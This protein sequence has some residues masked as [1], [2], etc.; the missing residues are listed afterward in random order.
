MEQGCS[1]SGQRVACS[2]HQVRPSHLFDPALA[3]VY[4]LDFRCHDLIFYIGW[5]LF[6]L[7]ELG[8]AFAPCSTCVGEVSSQVV[9]TQCAPHHAPW[10]RR[11]PK[12]QGAAPKVWAWNGGP[13]AWRGVLQ[14][15]AAFLTYIFLFLQGGTIHMLYIYIFQLQWNLYIHSDTWHCK[16]RIFFCLRVCFFCCQ[17][18][19]NVVCL[20]SHLAWPTTISWMNIPQ[21]LKLG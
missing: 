14:L 10:Y 1:T 11:C 21:F 6:F 18:L 16:Q 17:F 3:S 15:G 20:C 9:G 8:Q 4:E 19:S 13:E 5:L 12:A 2:Q 7:F